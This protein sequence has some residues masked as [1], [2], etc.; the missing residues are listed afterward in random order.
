MVRNCW[1]C[2]FVWGKYLT[3]R[4]A[5]WQNANR[6]NK[7]SIFFYIWT[8][9]F[10]EN[11]NIGGIKV[12][13]NTFVKSNYKYKHIYDFPEGVHQCYMFILKCNV[14]YTDTAIMG[15]FPQFCSFSDSREL[16]L[17]VLMMMTCCWGCLASFFC[18]VELQLDWALHWEIN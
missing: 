14:R 3:T 11:I 10:L 8:H 13:Q 18:W 12:N 17:P 5:I 1:I 15:D 6:T 9:C 7:F 16:T 4:Y 2:L